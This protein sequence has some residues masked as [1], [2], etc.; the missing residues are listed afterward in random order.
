MQFDPGI[1]QEQYKKGKYW[2]NSPVNIDAVFWNKIN[3]NPN[4]CIW[5]CDHIPGMQGQF[6]TKNICWCNSPYK[7][8]K[9]A[10]PNNHWNNEKQVDKIPIHDFKNILQMSNKRKLP[11]SDKGHLPKSYKNHAW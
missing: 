10:K 6:H 9:G 1:R 11:H 3:P 4:L 7:L 2:T 5:S 8:I